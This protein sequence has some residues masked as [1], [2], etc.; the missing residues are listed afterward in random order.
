MSLEPEAFREVMGRLAGGVTVVTALGGDG[1]PRGFTATA[2]CSVSLVPPL[3]LVCVGTD[4]NTPGA[5]REAGRYAL[6]FLHSEDTA[7]AD[8]FAGSKGRKFEGVEWVVAP[9]GSPLLPGV[10]AW[11]ECDV[12]REVDAGDHTIFIGRV[13]AAAIESATGSPL[14]HFGGRYHTVASLEE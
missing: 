9:G 6:S 2:V 1:L 11:V 10:L 12:E 14:V 5:I 3:V 4:A 7:S 8:R 13:T